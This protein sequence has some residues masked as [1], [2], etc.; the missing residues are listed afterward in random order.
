MVSI[1]EKAFDVLST[2]LVVGSEPVVGKNDIFSFKI[3]K[4]DVDKLS[5]KDFGPDMKFP[6]AHDLFPEGDIPDSPVTVEVMVSKNI[7]YIL[8]IV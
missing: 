5:E 1:K 3:Y 4:E 7:A 8:I 6:K 2:K